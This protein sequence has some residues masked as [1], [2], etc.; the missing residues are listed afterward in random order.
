MWALAAHKLLART[1]MFDQKDNPLTAEE[2]KRQTNLNP[3]ELRAMAMGDIHRP[4]IQASRDK[5][6]ESV[7]LTEKLL[8]RLPKG[9]RSPEIEKQLLYNKHNDLC[10]SY[11]ASVGS[12]DSGNFPLAIQIVAVG[13]DSNA[14]QYIKNAKPIV[15]K[16][17]FIHLIDFP[18]IR[19][20]ENP[21]YEVQMKIVSRDG[22]M[23]QYI[24]NPSE[25]VQ[26][27][28]ARCRG[29][30]AINGIIKNGI[31][32]SE[33][34]QLAAVTH[35]GDAIQNI[36][37]YG[38]I[39]SEAVQ[40]AAINNDVTVFKYIILSGII[41]SKTVQST[42]IEKWG[43]PAITYINAHKI[44]NSG[45]SKKQWEFITDQHNRSMIRDLLPYIKDSKVR[46]KLL[47]VESDYVDLK[48]TLIINRLGKLTDDEI[49]YVI[50]L[51]PKYAQYM[52]YMPEWAAQ[53]LA[54][55]GITWVLD[56]VKNP[57]E[58]FQLAMVRR[59]TSVID[60][61]DWL[62]RIKII[63]S[64]DVQIAAINT[65]DRA[66]KRLIQHGITP[67][68]T[69]QLAAVEKSPGNIEYIKNPSMKVQ[70][71]ADNWNKNYYERLAQRQRDAA[72][73]NNRY[74][75]G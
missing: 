40:E 24:K 67:S 20:I 70:Q 68:E 21:I 65:D 39:P 72:N 48:H 1:E 19:F 11:I 71:V 58:E 56:K 14:L 47:D 74:I 45:S 16:S 10:L 4:T 34:V 66:L 31:K 12:V 9:I 60:T 35:T 22:A 64:D 27:A 33:D 30:E 59:Y 75:D 61:I 6:K 17:A 41:P 3:Y 15:Q 37:R 29:D 53:Q 43:R 57:S 46:R 51:D 63:P 18:Q 44:L 50:D 42:A 54:L 26:L 25:E 32:P 5:W 2:F 62:N 49:K 55:G 8:T 73:S 13:K 38:I 52:V 36:I 7:E 28:A 23:I 69:V